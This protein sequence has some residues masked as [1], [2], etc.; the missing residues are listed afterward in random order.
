MHD[1]R[2]VLFG[3]S[4]ILPNTVTK[5]YGWTFP[6]VPRVQRHLL[7]FCAQATDPLNMMD[8]GAGYGI[9]SLF[10]LLTKKIENLYALEKQKAQSEL[11]KEV[12]E[13]SIR[14]HVDSS[15]P[16]SGFK[17][18]KKDFLTLAP[19]FSRGAFNILNANKVGH[20]FDRNQT[21]IFGARA[22]SLLKRGGRLFLT[23]LTPS[24]G[25]EIEQFMNTQEGE[26]LPGFVFYKL[27]TMLVDGTQPGE[28]RMLE[29]R[30]PREGEESAHFFQKIL[31]DRVITDRV[32]HYH[33][34]ETLK[35]VLGDGFRILETIITTPEE[36]HGTD[37]MIS[38]VAEKI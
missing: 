6:P 34:A 11:L 5:D 15:F 4:V 23:S 22:N 9:D 16:L 19:D 28:S 38:I 36:N 17:V 13:S 3:K 32:M 1:D 30:K 21:R 27:E 33:T 31:S 12:V 18:F 24:P 37:H 26:D 7:S 35:K 8:I 25:S 2:P 10:A 29:V 14:T 20:F